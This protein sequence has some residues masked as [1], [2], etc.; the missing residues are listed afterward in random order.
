[1]QGHHLSRLKGFY[2]Q[3]NNCW[4]NRA[5]LVYVAPFCLSMQVADLLAEAEMFSQNSIRWL[6]LIDSDRDQKLNL[7][8]DLPPRVTNLRVQTR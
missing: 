5:A 3:L 1:M 7:G 6:N 4:V 2:E 8:E